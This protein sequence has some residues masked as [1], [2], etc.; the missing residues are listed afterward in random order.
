MLRRKANLRL[1]P[2]STQEAVLGSWLEL[3]SLF[4]N[5]SFEARIDA[6]RKKVSQPGFMVT[7]CGPFA[8][9]KSLGDGD[10]ACFRKSF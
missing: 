7:R 1:H 8:R 10:V 4:C 2:I 9:K 6:W 5:A 3:R